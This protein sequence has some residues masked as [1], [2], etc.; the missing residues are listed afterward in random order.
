MDLDSIRTD[1]EQVVRESDATIA[2]LEAE[3]DEE[4]GEISNLDQHGSDTASDISEADREEAL[5]EAAQERRGEAQAALARLDAGS[6][7]V[8]IDCG[9]K[10]NEERLLFRPEASRCLSCQEKFESA[11]G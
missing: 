5:V 9:E 2:V 10:I 6:Y 4:P 11:E 1:L 7:G 8:C 3:E